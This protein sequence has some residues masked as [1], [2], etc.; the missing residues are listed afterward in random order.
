MAQAARTLILLAVIA[1]ALPAVAPAE[2]ASVPPAA[3]S[4]PA[5]RPAWNELT[6]SQRT[7][8]APLAEDWEQFDA[9]G[10]KKWVAIAD[11]YPAMKPDEQ[12]RLQ[13]RMKTWASLSKAERQAARERYKLVKQLPPDERRQMQARWEEYQRTLAAQRATEEAV[14][15]GGQAQ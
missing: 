4:A 6:A 3:K 11:R 13:A 2:A 15:A 1:L 9:A 12:E 10:R 7:A 5:V 8:L 14:P